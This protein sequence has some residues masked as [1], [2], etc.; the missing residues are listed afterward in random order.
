MS[1]FIGGGIDQIGEGVV[2]TDVAI[3]D[4]RGVT[5]DSYGNIY[6]SDFERCVVRKYDITLGRVSTVVGVLDDCNDRARNGDFV[7]SDV[8][9]N[10][11]WGIFY[12]ELTQ[13][14]FIAVSASNYVL[15]VDFNGGVGTARFVLGQ[16]S[17]TGGNS[18]S[19]DL[20]L[21]TIMRKPIA[22]F[23]RKD[24]ASNTLY[25]VDSGGNLVRT[26]ALGSGAN[27]FIAIG[28]AGSSGSS[29]ADGQS[30]TD[31]SINQPICAAV[32]SVG[33]LLVVES[34]NI[35]RRASASDSKVYTI[36][37]IAAYVIGSKMPTST[38]NFT[39]I[40]GCGLDYDDNLVVSSQVGSTIIIWKIVTPS[41]DGS[42]VEALVGYMGGVTIPAQ[43]LPLSTGGNIAMWS[44][45]RKNLYVVDGVSNGVHK[46]DTTTNTSSYYAGGLIG[47]YDGGGL[48]ATLSRMNAPNQI[49][50]D[51]LGNLYI[52]DSKNAMI[53]TVG[54]D[55]ALYDLAGGG[56]I[57]GVHAMAYDSSRNCLYLGR[58]GFA[59]KLDIAGDR[60]G[61]FFTAQLTHTASSFW[62]DSF[63][64]VYATD[65]LTTTLVHYLNISGNAMKNIPYY[66]SPFTN[67]P[68][69]CPIVTLCG[70][71][72][73]NLYIM[74]DNF[75]SIMMIDFQ[76]KHTSNV[77]GSSDKQLATVI[78]GE[79]V[80]PTAAIKFPVA[81]YSDTRSNSFYF[82]EVIGQ[83]ARIRAQ[84]RGFPVTA[85]PSM[86]PTKKPTP[87]PSVR[88]SGQPSG[89]PSAQPSGQPSGQPSNHPSG[90]PSSQPS[91][92]TPPTVPFTKYIKP[93]A[94]LPTDGHFG[95]GGPLRETFLESPGG[96]Y[97][98]TLGNLYIMDVHH[99]RIVNATTNLISTLAG[100]G[101]S[102]E[103]EI[104]GHQ[105]EIASGWGITGDLEG[106]IYFSDRTR[107]QVFL[108][109]PSTGLVLAVVGINRQLG[110]SGDGGAPSSAMLNAPY[111]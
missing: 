71:Y 12:S 73:N 101:N 19:N 70:D 87:Q 8:R 24:G 72:L 36:S 111:E 37:D 75:S 40:L 13:S 11:P 68:L 21:F 35:I 81:C 22:V 102:S 10:R 18:P 67:N 20:A 54:T 107:H 34:S 60:L 28:K 29:G 31:T 76:S 38:V 16:W 57:Y 2:A 110:Y 93:L 6:Y 25:C 85:S 39:T 15:E 44:D 53:R 56:I 83:N 5:G 89:Q 78:P 58:E 100:G 43:W 27:A 94:G 52:Y 82:A 69:C 80:R 77:F 62:V 4:T 49:V 7:L 105:M 74:Y 91:M 95:D 98:D 86:S 14:L 42:R 79:F 45:T 61:L 30:P 50:G 65:I 64:N 106:N 3:T 99:L 41:L 108:Y 84:L 59:Q 104:P 66:S 63:F 23:V 17:S 55:G 9:L 48:A 90:Q 88:P 109:R 32:N 33:D 103:S 96:I 47:G 26:V 97:V 92:V 46:I 1:I 51:T